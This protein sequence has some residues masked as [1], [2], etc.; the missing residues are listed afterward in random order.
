MRIPEALRMPFRL[1]ESRYSFFHDCT[2]KNDH[3]RVLAT[4]PLISGDTVS[5]SPPPPAIGRTAYIFWPIDTDYGIAAPCMGNHS[6]RAAQCLNQ[7]SI[8]QPH[9]ARPLRAV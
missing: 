3:P 4:E 5:P 6:T 9:T 1:P 7:R 2:R 8:E